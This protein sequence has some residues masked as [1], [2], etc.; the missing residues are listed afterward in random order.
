ML[1]SAPAVLAGPTLPAAPFNFVKIRPA[2]HR[3]TAPSNNP[4]KTVAKNSG[5]LSRFM[6][7]PSHAQ[8]GSVMLTVVPRATKTPRWHACCEEKSSSHASA[9]CGV[10]VATSTLRSC[11][12]PRCSRNLRQAVKQNTFASRPAGSAPTPPAERRDA[13][14]SFTVPCPALVLHSSLRE[15]RRI[16]GP[17]AAHAPCQRLTQACA[18]GQPV[19]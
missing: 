18:P 17:H 8:P 16:A 6:L 15:R 4:R 1:P 14:C 9:P 10:A 5:P 3:R 11:C 19:R 2:G 13:A 7:T 12:T